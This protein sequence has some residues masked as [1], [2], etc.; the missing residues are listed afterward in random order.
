VG[1]SA[2][3]SANV[4]YDGTYI[5]LYVQNTDLA[6]GLGPSGGYGITGIGFTAPA[7]NE[8][9]TDFDVLGDALEEGTNP[10][11]QWNLAEDDGFAG[12][13]VEL[14]S[15]VNG[16]NGGIVGCEGD[17][18]NSR[19]R[20]CNDAGTA[21]AR[22]VI[23]QFAVADFVA[24]SGVETDVEGVEYTLRAQG[25]AYSYR[26]SDDTGDTN[27]GPCTVNGGGGSGDS[28]VPEPISLVL[29]GSGLLGVGAVR[30]RRQP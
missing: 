10:K 15:Y 13:T 7:V 6:S 23:F 20:T 3:A 17:F 30:R 28:T 11:G 25:G 27:G 22:Y 26:C 12:F 1:Y 29:L 18:G 16:I 21:N 5:R 14:G 2:C 24:N 19:L 9:V 4:T 8:D